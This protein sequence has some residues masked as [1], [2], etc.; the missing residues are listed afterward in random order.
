MP[1]EVFHFRDPKGAEVDLVLEGADGRVVGI[2]V[3]A[4]STFDDRSIRTLT[5]LRD[6]LRQRFAHGIVLYLGQ[7]VLPVGDRLT[8]LPASALWRSVPGESM[9]SARTRRRDS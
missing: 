9:G 6:R 2:E 8:A 7:E 4:S 5:S 3:K 1:H